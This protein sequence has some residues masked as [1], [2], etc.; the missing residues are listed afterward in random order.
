MIQPEKEI[1]QLVIRWMDLEGI[2]LSEISQ[3]EKINTLCPH[4]N[5]KSKRSKL[6]NRG[7]RCLPRIGEGGE[8]GEMLVNRYKLPVVR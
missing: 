7:E 5:V 4:F 2:M 6:R 8:N 1:L 3:T